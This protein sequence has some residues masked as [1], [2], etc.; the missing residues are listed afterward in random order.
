MQVYLPHHLI[1]TPEQLRALLM[2]SIVAALQWTN[3]LR[4]HIFLYLFRYVHSSQK[5]L[6]SKHKD[7]HD[8]INKNLSLYFLIFTPRSVEQLGI[9][10]GILE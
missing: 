5:Y 7:E 9:E 8:V 10:L 6:N 3:Q 1:Y 2:T 4:G